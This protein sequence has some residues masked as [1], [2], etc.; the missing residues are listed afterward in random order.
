MPVEDGGTEIGRII[1]T[2]ELG[3]FKAHVC[4][5]LRSHEQWWQK[6]SKAPLESL[7][8]LGHGLPG[9]LPF[10]GCFQCPKVA[11]SLNLCYKYKV[12]NKVSQFYNLTFFL[13][14]NSTYKSHFVY[15]SNK[16]LCEIKAVT[17]MKTLNNISL[18]S[19]EQIHCPQIVLF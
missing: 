7:L 3:K 9:A 11:L 13:S 10:T 2:F 5:P 12:I 16:M 15:T 19:G 1:W 8:N 4:K 6:L 18:T 17:F 14:F